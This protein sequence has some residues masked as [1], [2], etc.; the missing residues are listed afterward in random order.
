MS[1][2]L[3]HHRLV[4]VTHAATASSWGIWRQTSL[5]WPCT[6]CLWCT[7]SPSKIHLSVPWNPWASLWQSYA[8][9]CHISHFPKIHSQLWKCC[10]SQMT[11]MDN[12]S[13]ENFYRCE[14]RYSREGQEGQEG[15]D[16][17]DF[18]HDPQETVKAKCL[19]LWIW[20]LHCWSQVKWLDFLRR[21]TDY[22]CE[23]RW[24]TAW[25][26]GLHG[27]LVSMYLAYMTWR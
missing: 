16:R 7:L 26:V 21:K 2:L 11:L 4:P 3:R 10:I 27:H 19:R 12:D 5:A 15:R 14:V 6:I 1:L 9:F 8:R 23:K 22:I 13:S 24:R 18:D 17:R 20:V 25:G